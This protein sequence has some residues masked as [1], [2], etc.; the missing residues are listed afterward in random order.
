MPP[1]ASARL[2]QFFAVN[3]QDVEGAPPGV[4]AAFA[5]TSIDPDVIAWCASILPDDERSA[6]D[7]LL[8]ADL[9]ARFLLRRA[10]RRYCAAR[11]SGDA[12]LLHQVRFA[13]SDNGAPYLPACPEIA[14]SFSSCSAGCL[15]AWST[16]HAVGA[17]IEDR[18]LVEAADLALDYFTPAEAQKVT[19]AG[20]ESGRDVF[21]RLWTLKEAALKSVGEGLPFGLDAFAFDPTSPPRM[22]SAPATFG[23]AAGF[24][25]HLLQIENCHAALVLGKKT[26][27]AQPDAVTHSARALWSAPA[28]ARSAD[29]RRAR[30]RICC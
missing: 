29:R 5:R 3:A 4:T 8:T 16:H 26:M 30:C 2:A 10:F 9:R 7:R 25:S 28:P 11:A 22:L 1:Q 14:F 17:D 27:I 12:G 18:M 6:A 20:P 15:A 24:S 13:F 23:G 21:L 19:S